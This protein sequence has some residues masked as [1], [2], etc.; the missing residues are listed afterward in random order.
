MGVGTHLDT[1]GAVALDGPG[2]RLAELAVPTTKK[3]Y[4]SLVSWAEGFS[5]VRRREGH[6][7]LRRRAAR[8]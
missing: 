6:Q 5:R 3:G 8:T 4:E 1:R 7:Q 2:R